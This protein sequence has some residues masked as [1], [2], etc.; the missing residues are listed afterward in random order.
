MLRKR[1]RK[2]NRVYGSIA[3]D[4]NNNYYIIHAYYAFCTLA[5]TR[6][7]IIGARYCY[8]LRLN[9]IIPHGRLPLLVSL[10]LPRTKL[11]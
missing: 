3:A 6:C 11:V 8:E 5:E 1:F 9:V 7:C 4:G 10:I 2:I